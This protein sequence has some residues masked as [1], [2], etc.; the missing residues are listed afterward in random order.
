MSIH[1]IP[2][3]LLIWHMTADPSNKSEHIKDGV[4]LW[5][6]EVIGGSQQSTPGL[7]KSYAWR[8]GTH[9]RSDLVDYG[10]VRR[11]DVRYQTFRIYRASHLSLGG[12]A[13]EFRVVW[14]LREVLV[15]VGERTCWAQNSSHVV[16]KR[17]HIAPKWPIISDLSQMYSNTGSASLSGK[18][19]H[20]SLIGHFNDPK[21]RKNYCATPRSRRAQKIQ[22]PAFEGQSRL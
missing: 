15:K 12:A 17:E 14:H 7:M 10:S 5:C 2:F 9:T 21:W 8:D 20:A 3:S 6:Y 22:K 11:I 1:D 4:C 13:S 16:A 19:K 18:Q